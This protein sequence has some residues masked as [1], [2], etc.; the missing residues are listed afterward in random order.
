MSEN[1][2][3]IPWP[4]N[5]EFIGG[6]FAIGQNISISAPSGYEW[7]KLRSYLANRFAEETARRIEVNLPIDA[8]RASITLE[9]MPD[10]GLGEEGYRLTIDKE[11]VRI[12]AP[13]P[14]G[15]FYGI[16]T[17]LQLLIRDKDDFWLPA[18]LITDKPRFAWRGMMLDVAR[19]FFPV[20]V[21][22][23]VIDWLAF[24]K[25]N[26]LHLHLTDDQG[27]RIEINS[28]P[29]LTEIGGSTA[30]GGGK[31]GFFT[32]QDYREIVAYAGER[33]V[34]IVPEIDMPG[35]TQAAL[36]SYPELS[37]QT[38][39]PALYTGIEVGFSSLCIEKELTNRFV[40]DVIAELTVITTGPYLHIG[41]D[42]PLSTDPVSYKEFILRVQQIV[43]ANGKQLVGWQEI[44]Q[45]ELLPGSLL[46]YWDERVDLN[47][48]SPDTRVIASPAT[49]AYMDMKVDD[50]M[51]LGQNWA[52]KI[53]VKDGYGWD[54]LALN[55]LALEN[56]IGVE[57]AL[58]TETIL[59]QKDIESMVF[60]RLPGYAEI[61]WSP[62]AVRTWQHYQ[63][64]LSKHA[65]DWKRLGIN[66][67]DFP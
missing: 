48:L 59:S 49:K 25:M 20:A 62:Q 21:I 60:P 4:L 45:V 32:Q 31:G 9:L 51:P 17:I 47:P 8:K 7:Q 26:R 15:A 1:I 27:W 44:G 64:R 3:L 34:I 5:V 23:H 19:H 18:I 28:W 53:S 52:G 67:Y 22:K 65:L 58:W 39:T 43:K 50:A 6:K 16:Q 14:A 57:A 46:Q 10:P 63:P 56:V 2:A 66:Y 54:P 40:A 35:H 13:H 41:G 12:E 30:V 11:G 29:K 42:E 24:Y 61:G 33:Q 55:G 37:C 38:E 36:A